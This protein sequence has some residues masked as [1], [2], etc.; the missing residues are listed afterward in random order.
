MV[1]AMM[2][3]ALVASIRS[4]TLRVVGAKDFSASPSW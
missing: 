2:V 3:I 1:V 4:A